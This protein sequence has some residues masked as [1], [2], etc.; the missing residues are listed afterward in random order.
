MS[1]MRFVGTPETA[2]KFLV[3]RIRISARFTWTDN[4]YL[5][6]VIT[7]RTGTRVFNALVVQEVTYLRRQ[8]PLDFT[9]HDVTK[10]EK[11][12]KITER[13]S[14]IRWLRYTLVYHLFSE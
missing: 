9:R 12:T 2:K 13:R 5:I 14:F 6:H 8:V 4:S 1:N 3:Q 10:A 11:M 7:P